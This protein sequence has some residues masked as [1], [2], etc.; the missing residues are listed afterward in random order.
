MNPT[1]K[2]TPSDVP[3]SI[4]LILNYLATIVFAI[5]GT[6][7]ALAT[8]YSTTPAVLAG[9]ITA[10]GGGAIRDFAMG[11]KPFWIDQP[12]FII[13]SLLSSI[14]ATLITYGAAPGSTMY[15]VYGYL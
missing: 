4:S 11:K 14:A 6:R 15:G 5:S 10:N 1:H 3:L 2:L 12:G 8:G 7:L 9:I 13:V